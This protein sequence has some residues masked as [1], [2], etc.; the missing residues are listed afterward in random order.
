MQRTAWDCTE[1]A[2]TETTKMQ[3]LT[4]KIGQVFP[5]LLE[6]PLAKS[7]AG[8]K[9]KS[10]RGP[11]GQGGESGPPWSLSYAAIAEGGGDGLEGRERPSCFGLVF[12]GGG[13]GR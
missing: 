7:G 8:L 5:K 10:Q 1:G 12:G 11:G 9:T 3:L 13:V 4:F 2:H 6:L